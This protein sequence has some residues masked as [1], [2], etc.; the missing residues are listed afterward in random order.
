MLNDASWDY[1]NKQKDGSMYS[2]AISNILSG[3]AQ[4]PTPQGNDEKTS[5]PVKPIVRTINGKP[6]LASRGKF[7]LSDYLLLI[8]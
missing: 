8:L 3:N 5:K 1:E 2:H 7:N 6:V 4:T